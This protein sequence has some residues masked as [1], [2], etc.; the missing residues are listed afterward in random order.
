MKGRLAR[1]LQILLH[2]EDTPHRI[3]L[4]F[5]IGVGIA[6]SPLFGI[7]TALALGI[8]FLFRLSRAAM[9]IGAYINNPWTVAPMY[10]AGTVLGC[11]ML[12]VSPHGIEEIDWD[13]SGEAF[14]ASLWEG[15]RPY[16]WPFITGN[17]V[18]GLV[19]AIPAY[20]LLKAFLTRQR[21][22]AKA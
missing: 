7:H 9:L 6:F 4:S 17:S 3:A 19:A 10:T 16:L 20:F 12:G 21:V 1:A 5:A 2:V 18:L 22:T 13:A 11:V 14:Y 15:L 8:A